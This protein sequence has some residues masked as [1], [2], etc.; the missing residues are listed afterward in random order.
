MKSR[1]RLILGGVAGLLLLFVLFT[2]WRLPVLLT[3]QL[4]QNLPLT[5]AEPAHWTGFLQVTVG[6]VE[7]P[8]PDGG[9]RP[10]VI[11]I[12]SATVRVPAWALV[13]RP[14]PVELE[15]EAPRVTLDAQLGDTLLQQVDFMPMGDAWQTPE[16]GRKAAEKFSHIDARVFP[17]VPVGLKIREGRM[18]VTDSK[19][20]LK[21]PL[22]AIDHLKLDLWMSSPMQYPSVHLDM[23]AQFVTEEGKKIG[24]IS[25]GC[26]AGA[27]L[28]QMDGELEI[29]HDRLSDFRGVYQGAPEPFT[30]DAGSGG[31]V[32]RW[33]YK[34]GLL[35]ASMRSRLQDL[36]IGGMIGGQ[37]PW[38]K[39]V[40]ALTDPSGKID[41]TVTT[42]G[43]W[44]EPGFDVHSRLLS[45]LDW[46]MKERAAAKGV[47]IPGRNFY[48][49]L[50]DP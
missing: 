1:L 44:G 26:R 4:T 31:P 22:Y 14:M 38:Q 10:P 33:E 41:I 23:T 7:M 18:E 9:R 11:K 46:A 5:V 37:V 32:I 43:V 25:A 16:E 42:E 35:K 8:H 24:S 12:K 19:V 30:F 40:D 17:V 49:L 13:L 29:W 36:K 28:K 48:G 27:T 45:E 20:K 50:T 39:L 15:L 6:G 2:A 47:K 34:E 3:E 21:G